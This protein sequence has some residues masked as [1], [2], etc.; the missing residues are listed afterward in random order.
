MT[1]GLRI[2]RVLAPNPGPY[3]GPGTNTWVVGDDRT[4]IVLD[5]GPVIRTHGDAIL[6][7][8]GDRTVSSVIVTHTHVDHAPLANPLSVDVHAPAI[9]YA[10]GPDFEPDVR[11]TDGSVIE[12]AGRQ[13]TVVYTPGHSEDHLCFRLGN[14]LF[15][16]DHIMGGS[17][18]MVEDMGPYL[19]SLERIHHTG[20]DRL[21]PGHG[22]EMDRPD[23]VISWY[24]THRLERERQIIDAIEGGADSIGAVVETVYADVDTALHP[25]AA[26]SVVAHMRKLESEGRARRSGDEWPDSV[27]LINPGD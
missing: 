25:L 16:G 8:V 4:A 18:V 19:S 9:G 13:L 26:R 17:S 10:S 12:V 6:A 22:D 23:E 21:Y 11:V 5:P 7:T 3:T 14:S 24:L 20:L 27:G 15:T 1:H 2:E